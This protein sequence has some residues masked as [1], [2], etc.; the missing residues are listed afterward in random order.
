[1]E[2]A[3]IAVRSVKIDGSHDFFNA[4]VTKDPIFAKLRVQDAL[5]VSATCVLKPSQ[6]S[7]W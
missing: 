4:S 5:I 1:M 7:R 6:F 2:D 3:P